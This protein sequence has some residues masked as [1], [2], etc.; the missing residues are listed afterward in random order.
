MEKLGENGGGRENH[1]SNL[2]GVSPPDMTALMKVSAAEFC[3]ARC[4]A[5]GLRKAG[6]GDLPD[7]QKPF[8]ARR[9]AA[10]SD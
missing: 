6:V 2:R 9:N 1:L 5:T 10:V 4:C 7:V 3:A 8:C